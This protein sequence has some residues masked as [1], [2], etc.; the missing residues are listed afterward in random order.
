MAEIESTCYK[1]PFN[2]AQSVLLTEYIIMLWWFVN[3]LKSSNLGAHIYKLW[4]GLVQPRNGGLPTKLTF[5]IT[6]YDFLNEKDQTDHPIT[7]DSKLCHTSLTYRKL[8]T[9]VV[10]IVKDGHDYDNRWMSVH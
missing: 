5:W 4:L 1:C 7:I 9:C 6:P 3:R 8:H 2:Q 10:G